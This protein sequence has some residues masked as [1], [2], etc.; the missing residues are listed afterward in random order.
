MPRYAEATRD[1]GDATTSEVQM[2]WVMCFHWQFA[3]ITS[4]LTLT[5][6]FTCVAACL[7]LCKLKPEIY[8]LSI[9]WVYMDKV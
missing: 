9:S 2:P 5:A 1:I 3:C 4:T 6:S 7:H 8:A